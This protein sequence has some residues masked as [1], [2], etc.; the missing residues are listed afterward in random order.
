MRTHAGGRLLSLFSTL[1][2]VTTMTVARADDVSIQPAENGGFV[3]RA[4]D[5]EP[6]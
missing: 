4:A 1:F 6:L 3:C 5:R 2:L